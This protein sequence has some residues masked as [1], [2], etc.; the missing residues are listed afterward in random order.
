MSSELALRRYEDPALPAT[1]FSFADMREMAKTIVASRMFADIQ[2][3]EAALSLMML[4]DSE[5]LHPMQ[6]VRRFHLIKNKPT[7]RADA[8]QAE[9]IRQGGIVRW[10]ERTNTSCSARFIHP[11]QAPEPGE[12]VTFTMED[13]ERA[14][15][16][17]KNENYKKYPRNM[18]QARVISDGVRLV[19]P[20]VV[21]GICTPEEVQ[22]FD[23]R[24]Q[25]KS[26]DAAPGT[27]PEPATLDRPDLPLIG[28][29]T[30]GGADLRAYPVVVSQAV[31][32]VNEQYANFGLVVKAEAVHRHLW[33]KASDASRNYAAPKPVPKTL[34]EAIEAIIQVYKTHRSWVREEIGLYLSDLA[35]EA[36]SNSDVSDLS[37][38][39]D[40]TQ[41]EGRQPGE[42][43]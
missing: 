6:A 38:L 35:N 25:L 15:V 1:R 43:G 21:V 39:A 41:P 4:C 5:G 10:V 17:L 16:A 7:M 20:G 23:D 2:T 31:K 13:A 40:D 29:P 19:L 8:M 32:A 27:K 37:D 14:G 9:F 18:L 42:E 34:A 24:P 33:A 26:I 36:T 3:P 28:Q 22:D 11:T 30:R 12:L